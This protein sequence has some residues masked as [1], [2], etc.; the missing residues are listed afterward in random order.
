M[1]HAIPVT[2]LLVT[3]LPVKE[4]MVSHKEPTQFTSAQHIIIFTHFVL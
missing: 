4:Q 3:E 2:E 1:M